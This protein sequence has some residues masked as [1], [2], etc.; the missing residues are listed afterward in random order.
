MLNLGWVPGKVYISTVIYKYLNARSKIKT[1]V[2]RL[3][4]VMK[5]NK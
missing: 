2:R 5:L 4:S 3:P 1:M